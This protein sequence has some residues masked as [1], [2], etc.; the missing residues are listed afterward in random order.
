MLLHPEAKS[1]EERNMDTGGLEQG[2]TT[3][4]SPF[5]VDETINRLERLATARGM[6]IFARVNFSRD[7]DKVGLEM[8][9]SQ[10]LILGN[11]KGGTPLMV[12]A[13]ITALDLP[14]KVLAWG[15][16]T[17]QCRVSFNSAEYLQRRH[18]FPQALI[19]N[20][21]PLSALVNTVLRPDSVL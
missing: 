18:G 11:P 19:A 8:Q 15:D 12:A 4:S 5:A 7:A 1:A 10:L 2:I 14:L 3:L 20:I 16:A 13:P 6:T 17:G 9:P 21:A